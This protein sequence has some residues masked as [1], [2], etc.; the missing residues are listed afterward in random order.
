MLLAFDLDNTVVTQGNELPPRILGGGK[1]LRK[2][3]G[4]LSLC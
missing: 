3:R 4:I 1:T 2:L